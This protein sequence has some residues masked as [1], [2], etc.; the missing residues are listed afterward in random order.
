MRWEAPAKAALALLLALALIPLGALSPRAEAHA[1]GEAVIATNV[2]WEEAKPQIEAL[3]GAPHYLE[4]GVG[5][6]PADASAIWTTG[7]D[8]SGFVGWVLK[9]SGDG[10]TRLAG[11]PFRITCEATGLPLVAGDVPEGGAE[12]FLGRWAE[13]SISRT[14]PPGS[15]T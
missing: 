12:A 3:L 10:S 5:G 8:C 6:R 13:A 1:S 9:E 7:W 2:T 11:V 15:S 4:G 14:F